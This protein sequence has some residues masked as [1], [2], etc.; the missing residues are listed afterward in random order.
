MATDL[1]VPQIVLLSTPI[2]FVSAGEDENLCSW[3]ET[4]TARFVDVR[5]GQSQQRNLGHPGPGSH[6]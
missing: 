3:G 5:A 4:Q 1:R 6:A 2:G